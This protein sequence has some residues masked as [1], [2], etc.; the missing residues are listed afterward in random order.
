MSYLCP[1][2]AVLPCCE[3]D[4]NSRCEIIGPIA[5][6]PS[7]ASCVNSGA[8]ISAQLNLIN[9]AKDDGITVNVQV[10]LGVFVNTLRGSSIVLRKSLRAAVPAC[11]AMYV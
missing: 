7:A 3:W 9:A 4:T 1:F 6:C 2:C 10:S 11:D 5:L 8:I